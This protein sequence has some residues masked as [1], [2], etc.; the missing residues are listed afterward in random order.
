MGILAGMILIVIL[1]SVFQQNKSDN[2]FKEVVTAMSPLEL[3][4]PAYTETE[5]EE[6]VQVTNSS[7][8][9]GISNPV[10]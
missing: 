2:D 8:P 4:E 3:K 1:F 9:M 7:E 6:S 10:N 5:N